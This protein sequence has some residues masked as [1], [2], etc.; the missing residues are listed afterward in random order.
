MQNYN[1]LE[2]AFNFIYLYIAGRKY[3]QCLI[4]VIKFIKLNLQHCMYVNCVSTLFWFN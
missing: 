2:L 3:C 4:L 1:L